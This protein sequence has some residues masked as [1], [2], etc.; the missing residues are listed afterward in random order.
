MSI[1]RRL[2]SLVSAPTIMSPAQQ[3]A[4]QLIDENAVMVFSKSYCPY[5]RNT[6]RI[7]DSAGVKYGLYELDEAGMCYPNRLP[8]FL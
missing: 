5:C 4:Q 6:K 2:F 3:K 1:F 7:F 8:L